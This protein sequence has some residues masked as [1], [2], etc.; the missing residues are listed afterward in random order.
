[1]KA[2]HQASRFS[3]AH[4]SQGGEGS[5]WGAASRALFVP[6]FSLSFS[7]H[8]LEVVFE[9]LGVRRLARFLVLERQEAEPPVLALVEGVL[10]HLEIDDALHFLLQFWQKQRLETRAD[11]VCV[12]IIRIVMRTSANKPMME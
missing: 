9:V 7:H 4:S 12:C 8:D 10:H 2:E 1:M 5:S 11:I 6:S 3:R